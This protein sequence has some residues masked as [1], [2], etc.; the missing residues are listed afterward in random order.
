[1]WHDDRKFASFFCFPNSF[2]FTQYFKH[3]WTTGFLEISCFISLL[4]YGRLILYNI[5]ENGQYWPYFVTV[6]SQSC[7]LWI[8][9]L[10]VFDFLCSFYAHLIHFLV[11]VK[12]YDLERQK[13][14]NANNKRVTVCLDGFIMRLKGL[15]FYVEQEIGLF[16]ILSL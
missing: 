2:Y 14:K 6:S 13:I 9:S 1:M 10:L 8:S 11:L 16:V 5:F 12:G 15:I 3:V 4:F 7:F